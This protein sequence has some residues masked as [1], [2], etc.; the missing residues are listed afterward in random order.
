MFYLLAEGLVVVE[1]G[2]EAGVGGAGREGAVVGREGGKGVLFGWEGGVAVVMF[3][4]TDR[5]SI[6]VEWSLSVV[7]RWVV[8]G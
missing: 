4:S 8:S 5:L 3:Y 1:V 7:S 6:V 2:G